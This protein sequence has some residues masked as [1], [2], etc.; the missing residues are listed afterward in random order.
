MDHSCSCL[1]I[2]WWCIN[3][4]NLVPVI[5]AY[6]LPSSFVHHPLHYIV[7]QPA[8][9]KISGL[10]KTKIEVYKINGFFDISAKA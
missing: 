1:A 3:L 6:I 4:Y 10:V 2:Y 7:I 5:K 9:I 8:G